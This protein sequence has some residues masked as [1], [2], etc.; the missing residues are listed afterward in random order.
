V[1][2]SGTTTDR[3]LMQI[4]TRIINPENRIGLYGYSNV[5]TN[6]Q[7]LETMVERIRQGLQP[8][9]YDT[10]FHEHYD[11]LHLLFLDTDGDGYAIDVGPTDWPHDNT[12][13]APANQPQGI[14]C[15]TYEIK[16][17]Q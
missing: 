12:T 17:L 4:I 6:Y 9:E 16:R 7:E 1:E 10:V 13:A 2:T 14:M 3:R 5:N 8:A 11:V 15:I